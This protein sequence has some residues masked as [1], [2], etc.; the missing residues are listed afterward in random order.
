[1]RAFAMRISRHFG[2]WSAAVAITSCT[3]FGNIPAVGIKDSSDFNVLLSQSDYQEHLAENLD[4]IQSELLPRLEGRGATKR[5][6]LDSVT[7]GLGI[8]GE[9]GM[10]AVGIEGQ[11]GIYLTFE[12]QI[13]PAYMSL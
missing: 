1:M 3:R 10:G 8:E 6:R 13:L 11:L 5:W 4:D 9:A 2:L 7:V 12:K